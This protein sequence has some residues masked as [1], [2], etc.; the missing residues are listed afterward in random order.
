MPMTNLRG[1]LALVTPLVMLGA[2]SASAGQMPLA[3]HRAV[4]ELKMIK[5][6]GSKAP[7]DAHGRIAFDFTGS[8]CD[9]YVMNFRQLTEMTPAE[10]TVR[11][12]DMRSETFEDGEG[13]A[14]RFSVQTKLDDRP[15]DDLD[16]QASLSG[17]GDL[18][19]E[20]K[21]PKL[22]KADLG[23]NVIFPTDHIKRILATARDGGTTLGVKVYDGSDS[24]EKVF[25]TL[26]VIGKPLTSEPVEAAAHLPELAG[27][28]RWPVAISYFT[29]G[30]GDDA[31]D[32]VLSFDLYENG[33][34]RALKLDYGD[35]VL[36]GDMSQLELLPPAVCGK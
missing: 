1:M 30:K 20:L 19:I 18:S 23:Q 2:G 27:M 33:I 34:S 6:S 29:V 7:A 26:S 12:S 28:T 14:F 36:S 3:A 15:D 17:S 13:K 25:D 21:R 9:G 8:A 16:G 35:F 11:I 4:Y 24:G 10:G 31:P 22:K 5:S 32:Y